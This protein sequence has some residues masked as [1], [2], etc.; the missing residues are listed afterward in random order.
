[1]FTKKCVYILYI[2]LYQIDIGQKYNTGINAT[3]EPVR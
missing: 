2:Y 1:M 3:L